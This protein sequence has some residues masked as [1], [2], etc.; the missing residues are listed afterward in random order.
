MNKELSKA[1]MKRTRLRNTFLRNKSPESRENFNKQRNYC[2]Q[3]VRKSKRE[4]YGHLNEKNVTDNK[5]FWKTVKFFL[6]SKTTNHSKITLV[7]NDKVINDD[8]KVAETLDSFFTEAVLNLKIPKYKTSS[9]VMD[10]NESNKDIDRI[11]EKYKHHPSVTAIKETFLDLSFSFKPVVREDILKEIK[12]LNSAKATQEH[13]I[14]T[15]ILKKNADL[16]ANFLHPPFNEC[17]ETGKFP[18]CLKQADITPVFRKGSRNSKD[19]YRPVSILPNVSK[20]FENPSF[21]QMSDFFDNIF[22]MYQ[23]GFRKGFS[24]QHCLVA[25]LEKWKSCNDKGKSFGAHDKSFERF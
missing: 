7:E 24:A 15:K 6:S 20:I 11:V 16:F 3:L 19:Y 2:V 1:I 21:K 12:G 17:V 5:T 18:S 8:T 14:P 10:E 22:S 23:C 4:Y 13:D 25:M 9:I